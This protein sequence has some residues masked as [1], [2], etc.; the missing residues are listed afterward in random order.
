MAEADGVVS[1]VP[2]HAAE[3][4]LDEVHAHGFAGLYLDADAVAPARARAMA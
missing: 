3:E 1:V 2:P 4:V